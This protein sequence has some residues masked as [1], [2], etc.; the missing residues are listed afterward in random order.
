MN[1]R[2]PIRSAWR[3]ATLAAAV[4][5]L[6]PAAWAAPPHAPG[7]HATLPPEEAGGVAHTDS[8][9]NLE[10][11]WSDQDGAGIA[12]GALRGRPQVIAMIYTSCQYVC[13]LVVNDMLKLEG[14]LPAPVRGQVGFALFSFD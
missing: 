4:L 1:L 5:L 12:L 10:S 7:E 13:P 3:P 11:T 14:R 6:G 8:V 2:A 9:Y